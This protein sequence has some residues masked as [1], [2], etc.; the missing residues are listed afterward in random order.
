MLPLA[1]IHAPLGTFFPCVMFLVLPPFIIYL[2][3]RSVMGEIGCFTAL[4]M[5]GTA[6]YLF[7]VICLIQDT[8][9][10]YAAIAGIFSLLIGLPVLTYFG[11]KWD[12]RH[13]EAEQIRICYQQIRLNPQ[14]A[15]AAFRLATLIYKKGDKNVAVAIADGA[16]GHMAPHLFREE[17]KLYHFWK[18]KADPTAPTEIQ[19]A[20]C[21]KYAPVGALICPHCLGNLHLDRVQ[22]FTVKSTIKSQQIIAIWGTILAVLFAIPLLSNVKPIIAVPSVIVLL[23]MGLAA[24]ISAFGLGFGKK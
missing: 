20:A 17:H 4:M 11:D 7:G 24:V 6:G 9:L 5:A 23:S 1:D 8:Y 14:N 19:C 21:K 16:I 2:V 12:D 15:M 13:M 18:S 22:V 10:H 3:N